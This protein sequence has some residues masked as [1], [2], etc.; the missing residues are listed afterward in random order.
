MNGAIAEPSASIIKEP[1]STS[2][3]IIGYKYHFLFSFI[4]SINS[5]KIDNFDIFPPN[6]PQ[7]NF[8]LSYWY[9]A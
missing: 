3:K 7:I 2:T 5:V 1:N 9:L 6:H 4:N 8:Q